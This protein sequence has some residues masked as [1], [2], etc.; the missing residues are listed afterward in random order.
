[1]NLWR[2]SHISAVYESQ[3]LSLY[4]KQKKW[5][6]VTELDFVFDNK[7]VREF[8]KKILKIIYNTNSLLI[9]KNFY[10]TNSL[11]ILTNSNENITKN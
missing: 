5:I 10:N 7:T 8:L 1:M 11:L 4:F 3:N 2:N 6:T 9:I